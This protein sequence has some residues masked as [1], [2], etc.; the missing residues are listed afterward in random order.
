MEIRGS[1]RADETFREHN[2]LRKCSGKHL[3]RS[4]LTWCIV[5]P[6]SKGL[7]LVA[8]SECRAGARGDGPYNP[9]CHNASED[10]WP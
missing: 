6:L 2:C 3:G 7:E 5:A 4:E 8:E 10:R 9:K 1:V